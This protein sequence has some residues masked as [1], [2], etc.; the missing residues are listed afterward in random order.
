MPFRFLGLG[1]NRFK[2]CFD[3]FGFGFCPEYFFRQGQFRLIENDVFSF[4][5]YRQGHNFSTMHIIHVIMCI[6]NYFGFASFV[7]C[8][9]LFDI[10]QQEFK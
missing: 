5:F 3:G 7:I 6:V 9:K 1:D 8:R 4:L 10:N 2:G